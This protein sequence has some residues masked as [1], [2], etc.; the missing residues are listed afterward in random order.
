VLSRSWKKIINAWLTRRIPR[1]VSHRLQHRNIFILPSKTG[2]MFLVLICLLWLLGTNYQNNLVLATAFLLLALMI[3]CI[4]HTYAYLAG[5]QITVTNTQAGFVGTTGTVDLVI[6]RLNTRH[7][8]SVE[9]DWFHDQPTRFSLI[10]EDHIALSVA[11]PLRH[12]GWFQ[13]ERL[14]VSTGF[15]LGLIV[16]WS[17]LD[18]EA[19]ILAYPQPIESDVQPVQQLFDDN[20]DAE[21]QSL[22]SHHEKHAEDEEFAGL[23]EYHEGDA[24]RTIDWRSMAR[25][26]GLST[27]IYEDY[28]TQHYWLNWQQ[29]E[30]MSREARL[31]RLCYCVLQQAEATKNNGGIRYGL[32]LPNHSIAPNAGEQHRKALLE[33]LALFESDKTEVQQ[34]NAGHHR[35]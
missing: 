12:R 35:P 6:K 8:E 14:K 28:V 23:R 9:L 17:Y 20:N 30:G 7:Y 2:L 24:L 19:P 31:S 1:R 26:Q 25:G 27:R 29:F 4:H 18:F 3:V 32:C 13:P 21:H 33:A 10:N 11:V 5:L 22:A 16:A 34:T 15:P